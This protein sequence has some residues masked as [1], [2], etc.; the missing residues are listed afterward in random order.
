MAASG[1]FLMAVDKENAENETRP[2]F[3]NQRPLIQSPTNGHTYLPSLV[4]GRRPWHR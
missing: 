4:W 2:S 1:E 3:S